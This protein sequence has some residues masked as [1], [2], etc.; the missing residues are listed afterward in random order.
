MRC[1]ELERNGIGAC[2][3]LHTVAQFGMLLEIL[4]SRCQFSLQPCPHSAA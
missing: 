4:A 2:L 3:Q 1:C